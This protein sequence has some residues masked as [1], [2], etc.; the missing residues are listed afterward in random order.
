MKR[1]FTVIV[2]LLLALVMCF[3]LV[4]CGTTDDPNGGGKPLTKEEAIDKALT[5][6]DEYLEADV[7]GGTL[8]YDFHTQNSEALKNSY[9][10]A[11][12]G[13]EVFYIKD[14]VKHMVDLK[15]GLRYVE[16][17]DGWSFDRTLYP[18]GTI[19]YVLAVL[20]AA[21]DNERPA[22]SENGTANNH[23]GDIVYNAKNKTLSVKV[24]LDERVNR[25][26]GPVQTTYDANGSVK[27][28]I[29]EYFAEYYV[30][31]VKAVPEIKTL[32]GKPLTVKKIA[33]FIKNT[34]K[35]SK[36]SSMIAFIEGYIDANVSD[37]YDAYLEQKGITGEALTAAKSR[38]IGQAIE[39]A[40]AYVNAKI[41]LAEI[42]DGDYSS[43]LSVIEPLINGTDEAKAAVLDEL[44]EYI[45]LSDVDV[46]SFDNDVTSLVDTITGLL[47]GIKIKSLID[48]MEN[49]KIP[50]MSTFVS[51][52]LGIAAPTVK[53]I[54]AK[55]VTFE[56]LDATLTMTLDADYA[57]DK[58]TVDLLAAHDYDE[59]T[60]LPFLSDNDYSAK[61]TLALG[62]AP[63]WLEN[64]DMEFVKYTEGSDVV[65]HRY[66]SA[67]MN[68]DQNA[69]AK[70]YFETRMLDSF[71]VDEITVYYGDDDARYDNVVTFDAQTSSF[72]FD[73]DA[74]VAILDNEIA[75]GNNVMTLNVR[76]TVHVGD[77]DS[78]GVGIAVYV[79]PD[80]SAKTVKNFLTYVMSSLQFPQDKPQDAP[81]ES[82]S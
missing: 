21:V 70:V 36:D 55:P 16:G 10:F 23:Y 27:N 57:V 60:T 30:D 59:Q 49:K 61:V 40:L 46:S 64:A 37:R 22:A 63:Q 12:K 69:D 24:E 52:A 68:L 13:D 65:T 56:A 32:F 72:V 71:T 31:I 38:T 25:A 3:A 14:D 2:T 77:T 34:L 19:E 43:V 8:S 4:A 6:L 66:I 50:G 47:D 75:Q 51:T 7:Q 79:V 80:A 67:I 20:E 54:I 81:Q 44:I 29:D 58:I 82:A 9:D 11:K 1:K 48:D 41:D 33:D 73:N 35:L 45:A 76:A 5:S 62:A 74:V 42:A 15:T 18:Q 53:E 26:L 78:Y 39:G 17:D 28:L